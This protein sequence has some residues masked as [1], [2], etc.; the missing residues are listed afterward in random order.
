MWV[1]VRVCPCVKPEELASQCRHH[2]SRDPAQ[3]ANPATAD[4]VEQ[5]G[6]TMN[7]EQTEQSEQTDQTHSTC[8]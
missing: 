5:V 1:S 8:D 4:Q 3:V 2:Q 6:A 7:K